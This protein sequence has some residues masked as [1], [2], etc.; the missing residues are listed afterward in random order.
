M[1]RTTKWSITLILI[2]LLAGAAV[3]E[4]NAFAR[5]GGSRSFGSSGSRSYSSPSRSTSGTTAPRQAPGPAPAQ[6]AGGGFLRSMAGGLVGG[7]LGSMLFSSLGFAGAGGM[8][9]GG[10]IGLI[11]ILLLCGAGYFIYTIIKKKR[12]ESLA[13]ET[14]SN[15]GRYPAE[16]SGNNF[17]QPGGDV[18]V[19]DGLRYIRQ[20]DA[21][22]DETRFKDTAMDIFFKIQGAWANRDLITANGLVTDE[23]KNIF[24]R[25]IDALLKEKKI[26]K[27]DNI[28]VRQV[29]VV[30]A[31]Q[32]TGQDF[33]K[34]L[35][36]ANLLD[37]T[38]DDSTGAVVAG[39]KTEPV[40]FEECWT[41]TRAVG[42]NPWKLS[43]ISQV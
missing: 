6:P 25:D 39:S 15:S 30:E 17:D 28:A 27:L 5:A 40:K 37:Y 34:A 3:F 26:N 10:G 23:M 7:M 1:K 32:E 31:W 4:Q 20:M 2:M 41:F 11:E 22:F 14:A 29:E 36:S 8:G 42:N 38:V 13:Y 21:S 9:G 24:Q 16:V 18:S 19:Q 43:A 35:Y 12:A 33:I